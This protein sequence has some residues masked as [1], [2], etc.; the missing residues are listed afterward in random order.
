M[1]VEI[2]RKFLVA[3]DD[4]KQAVDSETVME[5]GYLGGDQCSI[6]VRLEGEQARLNIKSLTRGIR[7]TEFEYPIDFADAKQMLRDFASNTVSKTRHYVQHGS[8][9]WEIDVFAGANSGLV[10]AEIELDGEQESFQKPGWLGKEV[11]H[12]PRFL[13]VS[14][15]RHP[16]Q[17]W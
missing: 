5:Q 2:E 15:A 12:D 3:N 17:D 8:H 11:S 7:R 13:N 9:R 16:Y 4:W 10:V 14:L 1:P 6:R